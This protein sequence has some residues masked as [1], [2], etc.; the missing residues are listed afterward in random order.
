MKTIPKQHPPIT[1]TVKNTSNPDIQES[2]C[3]F[4]FKHF[5]TKCISINEFNN[6]YK[7]S[8][9]YQDVISSL[10]GA[11]LPKVSSL[12]TTELY[13]GSRI[14]QQFHFHKVKPDKFEIIKRILEAYSFSSETIEQILD[15]ENIYQF[16]GNLEGQNVES[17]VICE[18]N[19]GIIYVLFFD[20]N[21]HI[22][23]NRAKVGE[24]FSFSY[25][26][27]ETPDRC[28][29]SFCCFAKDY[30]DIEKIKKSYGYSY[31]HE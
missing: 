11:I 23:L 25:C 9:T 6:F 18:Y 5:Q 28:A 16:I 20:T 12:S 24:S 14:T 2:C 7:N 13:N 29:N 8:S 31:A 1:K 10:L 3:C 17:R 30:L 4:N 26:P 27:Y 22:Y 15:G 19:R 21:H